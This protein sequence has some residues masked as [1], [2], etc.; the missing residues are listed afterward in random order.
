MS[1]R[2]P[3][4]TPDCG[5]RLLPKVIDQRA[6]EE[7]GRPW[8]SLPRDDYD[9][10]KGFEDI[11]YARFS[12]AINK[13][14]WFIDEAIGKST[15]FE[16]IAYL[17][18][19]DVRYHMMQMA[20]CKTGHKVLFSAMLNTPAV[21]VSLMEQTDCKALFTAQGVH[22]KDILA[23]RPMES[24]VIPELED[25][26][27]AGPV[28]H[29][30]YEKTFEEAEHDPYLVLHT[31]GTTGD[32]CTS[33]FGKTVFLP[34]FRHHTATAIDAHLLIPYAN[35]SKAFFTPW[36][37]EEISRRADA[38]ELIKHFVHVC[39]G[40]AM[41]SSQA[42]RVWAKYTIIQNI[43]GATEALAAVQLEADREDY[44]YNYFDVFSDGYEFRRM[45]D[46]GYVSE[47]GDSKDLYELVMKITERSAPIAS[48][49]ARQNIHPSTTK[50]P[51]P[52]WLTGDLWTPH[53]DPAK[54][55]FA[56]RFVC[57]KDDLISFST[58]VTGHPAA[59]ERSITAAD[60]VSSAILIG[61]KHQQ[62]LALVELVAG[63][64]P[65]PELSKLLWEQTIEPANG[66]VLTHI[67]VAKTHV[68][69]VPA[70][71]FVRTPKGNIVRKH[72]EEKFKGLI[73]E[74]FEKHGDKWQEAKERYGSISQ[75]TEITVEIN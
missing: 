57:R 33:V 31:S 5:R 32:P 49:H 2:T 38:E 47:E 62:P 59:L 44:A 16:T 37:M 25:L 51:L 52:E 64:E 48:W 43:W 39:F 70:N 41:L 35:A 1:P 65:S 45:D 71:G 36:V 46:T 30:P 3:V 26:L 28:P 15:S 69:L 42:A 13:L 11:S 14:A 12:N 20:V 7:P 22:V 73:E 53:P 66:K 74:L 10:S 23:S 9:L 27:E 17:G 18:D 19:T 58:G 21:H 34:G 4:P 68:V 63:V 67:R 40:G 56:W 24:T 54:S 50:P 75:S 61:N 29:Y 60:Q 8:C 72:T 6:R 55:A